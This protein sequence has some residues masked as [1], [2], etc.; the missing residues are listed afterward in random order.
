[1]IRGGASGLSNLSPEN[2]VW[3]RF[4]RAMVP[5]VSVTAKRTVAFMSSRSIH[6]R[7]V[8]DIAAGHGLFGIEVANVIS[9]ASVMAIDWAN[10]LEVAKENADLAGLGNRYKT[11]S[12]NAFEVDWGDNFDLILLPNILHHFDQDGCVHML[13]KAKKSLSIG[14]SVLVIDIM[15]NPD[16]VSPPVQAA[17]GFLM[18]ATTPN[19]D[20]YTC[21]EYETMA[22][23][24]GLTLVDS[25][26]LLP[27]PQTLLQLKR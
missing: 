3:V 25:R 5:F 12:G 4:A 21:A 7:K 1:V 8:L 18:L 16:R 2:S 26:Q 15:P 23:A 6:P 13:S 11:T 27:T 14:G 10:V 9:D 20:A 24:A 17:F 19:G 22:G